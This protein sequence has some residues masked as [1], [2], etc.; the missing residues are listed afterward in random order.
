MSIFGDNR[1]DG[2]YDLDWPYLS[3]MA[4]EKGWKSLLS[5]MNQPNILAK[6]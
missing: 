1:N 3:I 4:A 5:F 6:L 2:V